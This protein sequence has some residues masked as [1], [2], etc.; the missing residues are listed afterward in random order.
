MQTILN[1][2]TNNC[3]NLVAI[4]RF[5]ALNFFIII[6]VVFVIEVSFFFLSYCFCYIFC[7]FFS[8]NFATLK[9]RKLELKVSAEK[10]WLLV[11]LLRMFELFQMDSFFR[12]TPYLNIQRA[13]SF[14]LKPVINRSWCLQLSALSMPVKT[15]ARITSSMLL[16]Q[17]K[18]YFYA[19]VTL[20][21]CF[22]T[23]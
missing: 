1:W 11:F 18:H 16:V 13:T 12:D 4:V 2:I 10:N 21:K 7:L 22:G 5:Y 8:D 15:W 17:M 6:V 20:W 14:F 23:K 9:S 19:A 3:I